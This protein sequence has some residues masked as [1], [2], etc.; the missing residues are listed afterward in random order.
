MITSN[1]RR[2]YIVDLAFIYYFGLVSFVSFSPYFLEMIPKGKE[3]VFLPFLFF[4]HYY[5]IF[6]CPISYFTIL[7]VYL[8]IL[9]RFLS[10]GTKT[11]IPDDMP[12]II[13]HPVYAPVFCIA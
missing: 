5:F 12:F 7:L 6:L 4:I 2:G 9:R 10:L 1:R 8:L 3:S 13:L 11:N